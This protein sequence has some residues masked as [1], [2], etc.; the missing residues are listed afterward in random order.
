MR[1]ASDHCISLGKV[2]VDSDEVQYREDELEIVVTKASGVPRNVDGSGRQAGLD[3]ERIARH[4]TALGK[5]MQQFRHT[6]PTRK[7]LL[8]LR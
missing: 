1:I 2:Q 6:L 3:L 5:S 8:R 7:V 4:R